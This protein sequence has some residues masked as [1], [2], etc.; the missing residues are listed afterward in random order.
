[1]PVGVMFRVRM[2][3]RVLLLMGMSI[4]MR[5]W[6]QMSIGVL[7]WMCMSTC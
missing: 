7:L 4:S 1:M 2:F 3:I 6:I 5:F